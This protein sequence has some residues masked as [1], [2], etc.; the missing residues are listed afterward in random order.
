MKKFIFYLFL[1]I[2]LLST[3]KASLIELEK[4]FSTQF[5]EAEH[6]QQMDE[7]N[8]FIDST[9]IKYQSIWKKTLINFVNL[10]TSMVR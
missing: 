2:L 10:K 8:Y 6:E 7:E 9:R 1:N 3:A 4:C 5:F